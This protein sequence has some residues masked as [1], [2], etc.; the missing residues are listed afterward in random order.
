VTGTRPHPLSEDAVVSKS[1][2]SVELVYRFREAIHLMCGAMP[3][4]GL[5]E[6]WLSRS[7]PTGLG[8]DLQEWINSNGELPEWSMGITALEAAEQWVRA[9]T[10]P[11]S[12]F[13]EPDA[14]GSGGP[15]G[16]RRWSHPSKES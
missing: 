14:N 11:G 5:S 6:I 4:A 13:S 12:E 15:R 1:G 7:D 10:A 16:Y 9:E 3:P 8:G 2:C